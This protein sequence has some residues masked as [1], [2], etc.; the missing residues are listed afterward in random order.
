MSIDFFV[1][2][3]YTVFFFFESCILI[4][5]GRKP[6]FKIYF[7][8]VNLKMILH[9]GGRKD[10]DGRAA[11]IYAGDKVSRRPLSWHLG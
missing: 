9:I 2:H 6:C 8:V 4:Y 7:R 1:L 10:R 5:F 11:H 3:S